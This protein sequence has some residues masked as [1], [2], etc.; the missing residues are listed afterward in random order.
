M[1]DLA[2]IA[3]KSRKIFEDCQKNYGLLQEDIIPTGKNK[4][5]PYILKNFKEACDKKKQ[6]TEKIK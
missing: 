6:Q 4:N 5:Q 3:Q 2:K 1:F